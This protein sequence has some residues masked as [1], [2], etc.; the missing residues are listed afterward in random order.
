[1]VGEGTARE[2]VVQE[3]RGECGGGVERDECGV[4]IFMIFF[5]DFWTLLIKSPKI[6]VVITTNNTMTMCGRK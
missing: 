4:Y 1:M 6:F 2:V 5:Y 3:R